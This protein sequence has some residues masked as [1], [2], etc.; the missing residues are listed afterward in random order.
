MAVLERAYTKTLSTDANWQSGLRRILTSASSTAKVALVGVGHPMRGDDFVGSFIVKGLM[1]RI[2][3]NDV[4]LFDAEDGIEWVTS[5]IA[6]FNLR[7]LI[8]LDACQM[9]AEPGR[10]ALISLGETSY[11]FFTT[12]GIPLELLV[13]RL[14]PSVEASILAIQPGQMGLNESLSPAVSA[15]ADS[16]S[17]FVEA[18][19]KE[20]DWF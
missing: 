14:L 11:P 18:T 2:R 9:N 1:K 20:R 6:A 17:N 13:S 19:L 15:T 16:I 7:H 8:L 3:T 12:H 4:V 5:K 10:V